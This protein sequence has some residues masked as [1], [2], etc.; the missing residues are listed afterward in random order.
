MHTAKIL[1]T[2]ASPDG[3]PLRLWPSP[4]SGVRNAAFLPRHLVNLLLALGCGDPDPGY[5]IP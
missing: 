1:R 3:V 4:G 5:L 2:A